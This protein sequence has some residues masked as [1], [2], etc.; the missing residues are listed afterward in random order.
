MLKVVHDASASNEVAGGPLLDE[1]VRDAARQMIAVALQAEV[2][3]YI[4]AAVDEVDE[5][6]RRLVVRN[7]HHNEREVLTAAGPVAVKVPRVNDRRSDETGQRRRFASAILPAW[8]GS[9]RGS[10]RCCRC[11]TCT[12]CPPATSDRR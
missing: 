1:L 3:A 9:R 12:A 11:C 5:A 2:A 7:G 8:P 10:L 6:G 4:D